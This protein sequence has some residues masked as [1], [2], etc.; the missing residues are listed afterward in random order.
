MLRQLL[1]LGVQPTDIAVL[2]SAESRQVCLFSHV[3]GQAPWLDRR[4]ASKG[5]SA[6]PRRKEEEK[7]KKRDLILSYMD[8]E[9]QYVLLAA[10]AFQARDLDLEL[11]LRLR[12]SPGLGLRPRRN[13][14]FARQARRR[15]LAWRGLASPTGIV[16][17]WHLLL[18]ATRGLAGGH[19][20]GWRV[21]GVGVSRARRV[22][23]P[24]RV[25]AGA[26]TALVMIVA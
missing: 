7:K 26:K 9:S 19:P 13:S 3:G 8:I 20:L 18:V 4:S 21:A 2:G 11:E 24:V 10:G 17:L 12:R 25:I 16:A 5:S 6:P 23:P 1:K 14:S 15:G 22:W